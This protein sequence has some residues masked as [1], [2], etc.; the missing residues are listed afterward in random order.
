MNKRRGTVVDDYDDGK[1][2]APEKEKKNISS[3]F[4]AR[5]KKQ[6][7]INLKVGVVGKGA[8]VGFN[9]VIYKRNHVVSVQ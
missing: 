2:F 6:K 7:F 5:G 8:I 9:D 3:P 4:Y 1:D